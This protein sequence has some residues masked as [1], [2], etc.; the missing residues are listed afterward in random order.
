MHRDSTVLALLILIVAT[1][2][3][4]GPKG[5][6]A[7][8]IEKQQQSFDEAV[9]RLAS[10]DFAGAKS[11]AAEAMGGGGL[12]ADQACEAAMILI[13]ASLET[14][15]L[16]TAETELATA[17]RTAMDMARIHVL[18]GRLARKQGNE[19]AAQDAFAKARAENPNI[20]IPE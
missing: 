3:G 5:M 11:A 17:E 20:A 18:R 16:T 4:C 1:A 2:V 12:S 13:E 15:D 7:A 9:S 6:P 14:G 10:R 8:T 19:S